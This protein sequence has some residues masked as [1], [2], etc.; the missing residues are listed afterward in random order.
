[1]NPIEPPV[2]F[3]TDTGPDTL[4][5]IQRSLDQFFATHSQVPDTVRLHLGIAV[6]EIGANIIEHAG[7]GRSLHMRMEIGLY[8]QEVRIT[9]TDDGVPA[10]M[11]LES[12]TLPD[13]MSER[14]RG[15]ALARSVLRELSYR[16]NAANHWTLVS[17]R[18][19]DPVPFSAPT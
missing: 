15:L 6:A 9:F 17:Q 13:D 5:G 7:S 4:D 19:D 1:M 11:N 18:F 10:R 8:P 16:R 2:V 12:A 14:G 3:E